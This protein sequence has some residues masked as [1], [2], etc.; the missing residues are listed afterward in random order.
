MIHAN[1]RNTYLMHYFKT[2]LNY[3]VYLNV[4]IATSAGI[5]IAGITNL[6]NIENTTDYGFFGFFATLCVY[7]SHRLVKANSETKTPWLKWVKQHQKLILNLSVLSG[8]LSVYYFIKLINQIRPTILAL[9]T[10]AV[11]ITFFYVVR[12]KKKNI[13]ELPYLKIHSIA[14]TWTAIIIAFPIMNENILNSQILLFFIPAHYLYFI[15][16]AIPFDIRD[17]QYDLPTQKTIPQVIGVKNAK[18][19]AIILLIITA[20]LIYIFS[21]V[22]LLTPLFLLAIIIQIL[23]IASSKLTQ[24]DFHYNVLIDGSIAVLGISYLIINN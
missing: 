2:I 13:R 19:V 12:I 9:I 4:I 24:K 20:I 3:I 21:K 14:F 6:F 23:L 16:V 10:I 11:V 8:G 18:I 17:L 15:A 22:S 1:T 7:N 5:L